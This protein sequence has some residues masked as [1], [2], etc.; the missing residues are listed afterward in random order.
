M[1]QYASYEQ[2]IVFQ[3]AHTRKWA[4]KPV[5]CVNFSNLDMINHINRAKSREKLKPCLLSH[6]NTPWR[7]LYEKAFTSAAEQSDLF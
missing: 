4:E 1:P 6:L 2:V 7:L 5:Q 3:T